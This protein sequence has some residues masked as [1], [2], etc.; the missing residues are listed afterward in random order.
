M[1]GLEVATVTSFVDTKLTVGCSYS[2]FTIVPT[3]LTGSSTFWPS[4][5][6]IYALR[7]YDHR[8][9]EA[10]RIVNYNLDVKRFGI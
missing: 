8:L 9:S 3:N 10:E 7:I 6:K 2:T 1:K 4:G 5:T